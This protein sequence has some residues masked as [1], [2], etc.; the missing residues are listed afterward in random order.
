MLPFWKKKNAT[1]S[2]TWW[3]KWEPQIIRKMTL[4]GQ[5]PDCLD[6]TTTTPPIGG[7]FPPI[8]GVEENV[9]SQTAD[10][11]GAAPSRILIKEEMT[12]L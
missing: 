7:M 10:D 11:D 6:E 12:T 9:N 5:P 1:K 2:A 4:G 3:T 8:E